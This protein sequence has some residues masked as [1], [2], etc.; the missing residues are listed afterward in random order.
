MTTQQRAAHAG[1]TGVPTA[2][3]V[4][5]PVQVVA[6]RV[7]ASATLITPRLGEVDVWIEVPER[8]EPSLPASA[9]AFVLGTLQRIM[10][11]AELNGLR[12]LRVRGTVSPSLLDN[13]EHL[14]LIWER[15]GTMPRAEA[16]RYRRVDIEADDVA[17]KG[18]PSEPSAAVAAFSGGVDSAFTVY[19]HVTRRAGRGNR[20]VRAAALIHGME[21]PLHEAGSFRGAADRAHRMLEDLGLELVEIA[22]NLRHLS[23][24]WED[25]FGLLVGAV[26]TLMSGRFGSGLIAS[27][28]PYEQLIIPCGSTPLTDPL[29]SSATFRIVHDGAE[30]DRIDK[31]R[32]LGEWD[33]AR[34]FLRFCWEGR[35]KSRN[36]GHCRKCISTLLCFRV[37]G[38]ELNCFDVPVRDE[39]VHQVIRGMDLAG[40]GSVYPRLLLERAQQLSLED[41]WVTWLRQRFDQERKH[42]KAVHGSSS[43]SSDVQRNALVPLATGGTRPPLFFVNTV[44]ADANEFQALSSRLGLDQSFY[45][46]QPFATAGANPLRRTIESMAD[47][48]LQQIR[49]VQPHGPFLIGGRSF[50]AVVAYELAVRLESAGETV[51]LFT[52]IESVGPVWSTRHLANGVVYDPVMNAARVRAEADGVSLGD[53]FSDAAAADSF[54]RW[55]REPASAHDASDVSRYV[56]AVYTLRPDLQAAFPLG[57]EGHGSGAAGLMHWALEHGCSEMGMQASLLPA[58]SAELRR[59][60]L[61]VDPRLRSRRRHALEM[62]LDWVNFATRGSIASLADRRRDEVV[63]I[64]GESMVRYRAGRLA[65]TVL[66]IRPDKDVEGLPSAPLDRWHGLET[67]G[68]EEH[69][70]VGSPQNI[71]CE[72]AVASVAECID[73]RIA[74]VLAAEPERSRTH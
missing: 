66:L 6:G 50:G 42:P 60:P 39:D 57:E 65:A 8:D 37:A 49:T 22:T 67:G 34:Q 73:D 31:A 41:D 35:D 74:D 40:T 25:E 71:L 18:P 38:V 54:T 24:A 70:V 36:C 10:A 72:P 48:C 53:V 2:E 56:H 23:L 5:N 7:R 26:L 21:I 33:A 1:L 61:T 51:E 43:G 15:W 44:A 55:L 64:A 63:R 29:M 68:L 19:R 3:L 30:Y 62:V 14:Q 59:S 17:E 13:L 46:L 32:L 12:R 27:S 47:H 16:V 20:D 69:V 11:E 4:L 52:A 45:V 28:S 9:D 58:R